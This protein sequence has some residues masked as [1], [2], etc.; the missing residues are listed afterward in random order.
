MK[1]ATKSICLVCQLLVSMY[2]LIQVFCKFAS[3]AKKCSFVNG[4]TSERLANATSGAINSLSADDWLCNSVSLS[5]RS[6]STM[7]VIFPCTRLSTALVIQKLIQ[8]V[9]E[10][11]LLFIDSRR[12]LIDLES[13]FRGSTARAN[14]KFP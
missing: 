6:C 12:K 9:L 7:V 8:Y 5:S 11:A 2:S 4:L 1:L 14:K 10:V 3:I 13:E